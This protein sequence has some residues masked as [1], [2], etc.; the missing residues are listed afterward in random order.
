MVEF[1][2]AKKK[3][4]QVAGV[5]AAFGQ[6]FVSQEQDVLT[7]GF[8]GIEGD[9]HGGTTRLSNSREPWHPRGTEMRNEQQVSLLCQDELAQLALDMKIDQLKPEWI[10]GNILLS[11]IEYFSLLPP[12]T[13]LMF[14]GGVTIRVDGARGPCRKSGHSIASQFAGREELEFVFPKIARHRRGLVGY[15][16][17]PGQIKSGETVVAR[18]W[19]QA[20]YPG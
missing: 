5:Y 1:I 3:Q 18:I 12:R 14:E 10:G 8:A 13:L 19:E 2:A 15:V 7:L 6:G 11:G 4:G 16:E 9:R 17:V 20:I